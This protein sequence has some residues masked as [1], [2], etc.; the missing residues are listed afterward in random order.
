MNNILIIGIATV[1]AIARTIDQFPSA[2]GLR[3]F[4][5]LT[6]A[7]GGCAVNCSTALAKLGVP[8]DLIVRVGSDILGDFVVAE[9]QRH[10]VPTAGVVRD[11]E[12][13]TAF[14]FAA[15]S[16]DGERSFLHTTG[17]DAT[18]NRG[19]VPGESLTGRKL[20]YVGG[21]MLMDR[22]DGEQTAAVLADAREAGA[23]TLLDTVYV[24]AAPR[25]EWE[26]RLRP[27]LPHLDYF[28]P[29]RLEARAF[30]GLQDPAEIARSFQARGVRNVVIK[31]GASGAFCRDEDGRETHVPAAR[32]ENVVDATGA[33]DCW[34]A[35]FL[36]GL[37]EDLPIA[38]AVALGNAVA[39]CGIQAPGATTGVTTLEAARKR[40]PGLQ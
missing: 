27:V 1:D 18:L 19:D 8:C 16:A 12:V 4:D 7:T 2:G 37:R 14:T 38:E 33:G 29:S 34:S 32:V 39:A 20:V 10:G 17:A 40:M 21:T 36:V 15:V 26:R 23:R 35:G 5:H 6:L 3:F 22:F 28:I 9:L 11:Q 25:E 24:E 31:L 30:S 13:G